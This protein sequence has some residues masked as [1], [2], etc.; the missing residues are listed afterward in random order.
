MSVGLPITGGCYCGRVRYKLVEMPK[1]CGICHCRSCRRIAGAESV[2]WAVFDV[3]VFSFTSERPEEFRSSPGV[4][5]SFCGTCGTTL[6]YENEGR[7]LIDVTLASLDDSEV[8]TPTKETWC[9]DRISWNQLNDSL[10]HYDQS[11]SNQQSSE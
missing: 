4:E 9:Q 3:G 10:S 7:A 8:L 1:S 2:G 11:S 6:T 5:R